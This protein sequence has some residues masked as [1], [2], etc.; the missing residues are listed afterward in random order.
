MLSAKITIKGI[1]EKPPKVNPDKTVDLIFKV[2]MT[3]ELPKELKNLGQTI[4]LV[5][6]A[7]N[8]WKQIFDKVKENSYY[9]VNGE[10]KAT[11]NKKGVPFIII[12]CLNIYVRK[13]PKEL[14]EKMKSIDPEKEGPIK[15]AADGTQSNLSKESV[16]HENPEPAYISEFKRNKY[17]SWYE[18]LDDKLET[19]NLDDISISERVHFYGIVSLFGLDKAKENG[20]VKAPI[21]VKELEDGKYTLI[22][23]YRQYVHSK[24]LNFKTIRAY[25]T[26]LSHEE[27]ISHFK[28]EENIK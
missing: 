13:I 2:D 11:V 1:P 9:I 12:N 5:R 23:G 14:K 7:P 8:A 26:D 27:F 21:A 22:A 24:I 28:I 19:I 17:S 16:I 3:N 18:G 25:I 20:K 15:D 10:P 4:Y 6:V